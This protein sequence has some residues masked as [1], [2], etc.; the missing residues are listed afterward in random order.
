MCLYNL[1]YYSLLSFCGP[2]CFLAVLLRSLVIPQ[3]G[4]PITVQPG[5]F[6]PFS[7]T[8]TANAAPE[9][10]A[11]CG[12]PCPT[13]TRGQFWQKN[14]L[15]T[16]LTKKEIFFIVNFHESSKNI[17]CICHF[18]HNSGSLVVPSGPLWSLVVP[19]GVS[20]LNY[21]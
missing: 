17:T 9:R 6:S 14:Y 1:Y 8:G 11:V 12:S 20:R 18:H 15:E 16:V 3:T 19:C 21:P 7:W 2:M 10:T 5:F 13:F 4:E